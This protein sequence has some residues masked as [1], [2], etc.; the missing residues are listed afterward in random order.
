MEPTHDT[1]LP[2]IVAEARRLG[3]RTV[4]LLTSGLRLADADL[5]R[6][7]IGSGIT[8]VALALHSGR[9]E[10]EDAICR[11]RDTLERKHAAL[12]NLLDLGVP[13]SVNTLLTRPGLPELPLVCQQ[14]GELGVTRWSV[15]LPKPTGN[16]LVNFD[17]VAPP[18]DQLAS[19]LTEIARA[20]AARAIDL[21]VVDVPLCLAGDAAPLDRR[22]RSA[23]ATGAAAPGPV[24]DIAPGEEKCFGPACDGCAARNLCDGLFTGYAEQVGCEVL[25][26]RRG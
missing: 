21:T 20:T 7:L 17:H 6:A 13:L 8:R 3:Y 24:G 4:T 5:A 23:V 15:F 25:R 10:T 22:A 2:R 11:N 18:L 16:C 9:P 1:R 14:L 26:P 12:R 19:P